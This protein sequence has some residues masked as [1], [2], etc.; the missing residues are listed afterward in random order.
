MTRWTLYWAVWAVL[1]LG[2][3]WA[4]TGCRGEEKDQRPDVTRYTGAD[5][6]WLG[7]EGN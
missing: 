3:L 5:R 4:L 2:V 1:T 6:P 7:H